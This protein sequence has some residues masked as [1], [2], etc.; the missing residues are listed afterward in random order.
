MLSPITFS[1]DG[2]CDRPPHR[3]TDNSGMSGSEG[4][5]QTH[6]SDMSAMWLT[7]QNP[8]S[9]NWVGFDFGKAERL[10]W[11]CIWNFNQAG[12]TGAG[13]RDTDIL[14]SVDGATWETLKG[15]GYPYR[16]AQADGSS[17][18]KATNLDGIPGPIDLCGIT[19]RYIKIVPHP[20]KEIGNWGGF[21]ENQHRFGLSAVRF[22]QYKPAVRKGGLLTADVKCAD[23]CR[24]GENLCNNLGLSADNSP[25]ALHGN[26]PETMMLS[27]LIP[28]FNTLLFDLDGTY[29]LE[30]MHIWNYNEP[31]QTGAGLKHIRIYISVDKSLW[32]EL[33]GEGYPY[34]LA[35]ADGS[36]N[37]AAT[38]LDDGIHSPIRFGGIRARYIKLVVS[39][40][41][42][43]GTWGWYNQYEYRYGLSAV[44]FYAAAGYCIEPAR[45]FSGFFSNYDGWSGGDGIF[46]VSADGR[47]CKKA[48]EER[49]S[50]HTIFIF[51]DSFMGQSDPVTKE[52]QTAYMINNS[53]CYM[54]G[55]DPTRL[56]RSFDYRGNDG[57][58]FQSLVAVPPDKGYYYWLQDCVVVGDRLYSFTDNITGD[59][60]QREG[61]QF[62]QVG[63]DMVRF[64]I[65]DNCLDKASAVC[66]S[67]PFFDGP[68]H[69]SFGCS[70][71][72][73]SKQSGMPFSDG[74]LYIYGLGSDNG[75]KTMLI[76]RV[77]PENVENFHC[78]AFYDGLGWSP[79]MLDAQP[80]CPD[81]SCEMSVT[82]IE[83]GEYKGKFLY[84][85]TPENINDFV[86]CRI[87]DTPWGPFGEPIMLYHISSH[88][89]LEKQFGKKFY[90]YNSKAH[91]HLSGEDELLI[92]Y[93]VNATDFETHL[94]NT[95]V[96]HPRFLRLRKL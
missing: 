30:E 86:A 61:F 21:L 10:G 41:A 40:Y 96:Y 4:M 51:G 95:D 68:H 53:A 72:P 76:S 66:F 79:N 74:Y 8:G 3:L 7:V 70:I 62:K 36:E 34:I 32:T 1:P 80:V 19:A 22:Y 9:N 37:L 71:L 33:Q 85:Y 73:M 92:S 44:R 78:Y 43:T 12:A 46:S 14:Y 84:V 48:P 49:D 89:E 35:Q 93:N 26:Q 27:N 18:L 54:T 16:F 55:T 69:I 47:D 82:P 87:G 57:D 60:T 64:Q 59:D 17:R 15:K 2:A 45:D 6:S 11:L 90:N 13:V 67:T 31:G 52:R 77:L 63:V 20:E 50:T 23:L 75:R 38:N 81:G 94:Q 25:G 29:P 39:G 42:G 24:G 5:Y 91:Y 28:D 83:S 58:G 65:K 88:I 56:E